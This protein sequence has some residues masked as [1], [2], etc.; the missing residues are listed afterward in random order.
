MAAV[1]I[2]GTGWATRVQV[3][4]FRKA[5][6]TVAG[7]TGAHK[8][9]TRRIAEE[10]GIVAYDDWHGLVEDRAIDVVVVTTPPAQHMEIAIA[11][12]DAGK[13]VICEKPTA[14]DAREAGRLVDCA[15]KHRDR[16]SLIDHEL[17]FL[18]AWRTARERIGD[19]GAL[20]YAEVRYSSPGRADRSRAW[21]WWNDQNQGGGI[22]GAVGSHFVDAL[23]YFGFEIEAA[24][25]ALHTAIAERPFG[26]GLKRA[27]ADEIA[28]VQLRLRN[29]AIA[30]M[31]LSTV[32]S[33][34]DE[35]AV[36]TLHGE[37]GAFRLV[38]E[39]LSLHQGSKPV[40]RI[41]GGE[42]Q[43]RPGNSPGGAFG[44]GTLLF[45]EA[46]KAVL[47]GEDAKA[48]APAA[49]FEDGLAQQHVLDAARRSAANDGRWE[50]VPATFA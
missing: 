49:T 11:A 12:L 10:L 37:S 24:Q 9:K 44:T 48:L 15:R 32:S 19:I 39:E 26:E 50:S 28:S 42:M 30:A 47:G 21:S 34:I 7:I 45:A 27:T 5:G 29:G 4:L 18:P 6:L 2:A 8:T 38:G 31:T 46:L 1:G 13:H 3:P 23:R 40:Q 17:R 41:A 22:W 36:I 25:A 14:L 35:P 20:R 43:S 33:W 16:L